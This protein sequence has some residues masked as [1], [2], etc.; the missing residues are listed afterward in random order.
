M[1]LKILIFQIKANEQKYS[2]EKLKQGLRY[3]PF[4]ASYRKSVGGG[5]KKFT[6]VH[7]DIQSD[8]YRNYDANKRSEN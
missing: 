8:T 1:F 7:T 2:M 4:T 5:L 6:V 3:H